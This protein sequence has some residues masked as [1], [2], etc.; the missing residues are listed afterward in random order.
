MEQTRRHTVLGVRSVHRC[1]D[2]LPPLPY[3]TYASF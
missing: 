3:D 2:V 1:C